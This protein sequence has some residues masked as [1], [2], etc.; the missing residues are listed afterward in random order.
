[1]SSPQSQP[2]P[3]GVSKHLAESDGGDDGAPSSVYAI[4]PTVLQTRIP[5]LRSL[6]RTVNEFR[7]R[8]SPRQLSPSCVAAPD[9]PR[10]G[11]GALTPPPRY[12]SRPASSA[13][14]R[15]GSDADTTQTLPD[16][17]M[18]VEEPR[19]S[20]P[21][22]AST[23]LSY[24][25]S[26]ETPSGVNWKY[27]NQ[28]LNLLTSALQEYSAL[29]VGAGNATQSFSRQLY[30]HA[31]TYLLKGLP[32]D[33]SNEERLSVKTALPPIMSKAVQVGATSGQLIQ[34][35]AS[36]GDAPAPAP[37]PSWVHRI[38]ATGIIQMFLLFNILLPYFK[39]FIGQAYQYERQHRI[40]ERLVSS[41]ISTV[42]GLGRRGIRFTNTI[43]QMNDGKVGQAINDVTLWW[44]KGVTGGIHEG[45]SE[46]LNI[47]NKVPR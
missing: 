8:S 19:S 25:S 2:L 26:L 6:R 47:L 44:L 27:A 45:V 30:L 43:C 11:E 23:L 41:S 37:E 9:T 7:G 32:S 17:A 31:L 13:A 21:T 28:G 24:R 34:C 20:P 4:L 3:C 14:W 40:S 33:L 12:T 35:T 5:R 42:D 36:D 29:E 15:R 22:A 38:F 1:M 16:E 10:L 18:F 39:L 46:G